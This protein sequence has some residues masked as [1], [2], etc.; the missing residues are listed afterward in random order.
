MLFKP[1]SPVGLRGVGELMTIVDESLMSDL[2]EATVDAGAWVVPTMVLWETAFFNERGSSEVLLERPETKYM[3]PETVERWIKAVDDRFESTDIDTNRRV[4]ALRRF[5]LMAL[6]EGGANIA[7]GTDSPQV[8]SV[9]GFAIHHEM[10][11]Y[12]ELGMTPYEVLEMATRRPAEYFEAVDDFG[13]VAEGQRA[14]L[15]LVTDNPFDDIR[16]VANRAGVM[17]NGRWFSETE[18]E[19]RLDEMARFYGN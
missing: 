4:A 10:A 17:L 12:V 19:N 14:D 8:F 6:H 3:P 15:L 13:M 18:I 16:N 9:P 2:V 1:D 11:L 7:L 5:V